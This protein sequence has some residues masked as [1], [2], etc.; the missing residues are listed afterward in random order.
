MIALLL[1]HTGAHCAPPSAP[2]LVRQFFRRAI[3][4]V[5]RKEAAP[6]VRTLAPGAVPELLSD[7]E[8]VLGNGTIAEAKARWDA[9]QDEDI[10][11]TGHPATEPA[12]FP[13]LTPA[14]QGAVPVNGPLPKRVPG[15][16]VR[17]HGSWT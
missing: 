14:Q 10:A 17:E 11:V 2:G 15:A 4:A 5:Q 3:A 6:E 8:P 1:P 7:A 12:G 13:A 9:R 16:A